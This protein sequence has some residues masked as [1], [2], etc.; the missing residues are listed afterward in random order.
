MTPRRSRWCIS[1]ILSIMVGL[2]SAFPGAGP[3]RPEASLD[4]LLA[5][6]R[7]YGLPLPTDEAKLVRFESGWRISEGR[8]KKETP[9]DYLGFLL[10]PATANHPAVALV[11]TQELTLRSTESKITPVA[12]DP[13]LARDKTI[14]EH[15]KLF[16]LTSTLALAIQCK[17]RGWDD[18]AGALLENGRG[19]EVIPTPLPGATVLPFRQSVA[20]VAWKHWKNALVDPDTDRAEI[21]SRMKALLAAEPSFT[22][23]HRQEFASLRA[24]L[25]PSQARPGSVQALIDG[26]VNISAMFGDFRPPDPLLLNLEQRGFEAV[27]ELIEHWDDFRLTRRATPIV[28]NSKGYLV[29]V[30]GPVRSLLTALAGDGLKTDGY[31]I[32]KKDLL[33]WWADAREIGE[34]AYFVTH[35]LPVGNEHREPN[36]T[37]LRIIAGKYPSHLP[38]IYRTI[39]EKRPHLLS[40]NVAKAV[41]KSPLPLETKCEFLLLGAK[42]SDLDHRRYAL[43]VLKDVAPQ[44]FLQILIA[45]LESLPKTPAKPYWNCPE[46]AFSHLVTQTVERSAWS[47]LERFAKRSDV[48]LRMEIL[49]PMDFASIADRQRSQRLEFLSHFLDDDEVRDE[50]SNS[51]KYEGPF[52]AS[53]ISKIE[54]RNFAAWQIASILRM[55]V[56][57]DADWSPVRWGELRARVRDALARELDPNSEKAV[58]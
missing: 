20:H 21:A 4:E 52:A 31:H 56:K 29:P 44:Q 54:V 33:A 36:A 35:I 30:C 18:L 47:A 39:L 34:E 17:S 38:E 48:G 26:I 6:Y 11:G 5:L 55:R 40:V 42:H 50:K 2:N 8:G 45:T 27:P 14:K 23:L 19:R 37:M 24:T 46:G 10:K 22:D 9:L 57:P 49:Y 58:R 16:G 12:P 7:T 43:W 3:D 13:A 32:E 1:L 41:G 53:T 51:L 25:E 15:E 28:A